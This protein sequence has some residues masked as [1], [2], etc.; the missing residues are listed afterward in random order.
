MC[1][2]QRGASTVKDVAQALGMTSSAATQLVDGLV[3]SGYVLRRVHAEDRRAVILTLSAK[4][5][6]NVERMKRQG[7]RALLKFFAVLNDREFNQY[8]AL[9]KKI[10]QK[11]LSKKNA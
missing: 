7:V 1:I 6:H 5:N 9:N 10:V 8:V 4:T 11:S 2:E 3:A